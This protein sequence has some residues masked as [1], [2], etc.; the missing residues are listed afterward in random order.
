MIG[1]LPMVSSTAGIIQLIGYDP[2]VGYIMLNSQGLN[3]KTIAGLLS[4][5]ERP[6]LLP[7]KETD[8][9]IKREVSF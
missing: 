8:A 9:I 7:G 4:S 5:M 3:R 6:D 1:N 2:A